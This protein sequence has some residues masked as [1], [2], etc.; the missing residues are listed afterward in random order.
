MK[1]ILLIILFGIGTSALS[2]QSLTQEKER[3]FRI[4]AKGGVNIN[5][6]TGVAY[7]E[8][9][10]Y[11]YLLGGFMQSNFSN[12]FG[13]QPEINF[14]Q[15]SSEFSND[16]NNVYNDLFLSNNG[17][18]KAKMNYLEVPV[19]LNVNI[20]PT[21]KVKLQLGPAY[22]N[23]LKQTVDS[24]Q[25]NGSVFENAEWSAIGGLQLQLP[26]IV[27]GGRYKVGLN[28]INDI[29]NR[30]RWRSQAIQIFAGITL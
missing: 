13:L 19:L 11:N 24:L 7:K 3:F 16:A 23:V 28:N 27:I 10:A 2:A 26:L 4:G 8:G 18:R 6:I 25:Y 5:K 22:G 21:K 12:R 15:S 9:F 30:E 14:V 20:G 17:Q 29:D 1:N